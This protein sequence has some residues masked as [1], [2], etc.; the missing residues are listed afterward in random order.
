M[1]GSSKS[2][3]DYMTVDTEWVD[4]LLDIKVVLSMRGGDD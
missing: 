3:S 4:I 1:D 2:V